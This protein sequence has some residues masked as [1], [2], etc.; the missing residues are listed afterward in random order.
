MSAS[1]LL[2]PAACLG[3]AAFWALAANVYTRAARVS[4]PSA[5][6]LARASLSFPFFLLGALALAPGGLA[7]VGPGRAGWLVLS[8]VGSYVL[9]DALFLASARLLG[10]PVALA[11]SSIYPIWSALAG[12][13]F[14]GQR[15]SPAGYAGVVLVVAGVAA[16]VGRREA[17]DVG[18]DREETARRAPRPG[19]AAGVLLA[20][21]TSFLWALNTFAIARGGAGLPVAVVNTYRMGFAAALIPLGT[22]L[23]RRSPRTLLVP[24]GERRRAWPNLHLES[25]GGTALFV[26]GLTHSPLAVAAALTSLAPV[27]SVPFAFVIGRE[28]LGARV[29]AGI[30]VVTAGIV[31]LVAFGRA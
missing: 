7:L 6:N 29:L 26:I 3:S 23:L 28:R 13:L 10:V 2:G 30:F 8:V 20:L 24:A 5:V 25:V 17:E 21:A 19:H 22:L 27:L 14:L 4:S 12:A 11:V 15:V 9:G 1:F 31:L 18:T 16:V